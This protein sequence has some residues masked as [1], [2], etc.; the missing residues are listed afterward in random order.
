M[1]FSSKDAGIP[2]DKL[3]LWRPLVLQH[4]CDSH[5]EQSRSQGKILISGATLEPCH[6]ECSFQM[7]SHGV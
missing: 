6:G 2:Y 5:E 4:Y 3:S 7:S 1:I